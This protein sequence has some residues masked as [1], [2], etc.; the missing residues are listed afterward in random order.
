[1]LETAAALLNERDLDLLDLLSED[2]ASFDAFC[3]TPDGQSA[4]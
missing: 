4:L 3:R 2:A 1:L